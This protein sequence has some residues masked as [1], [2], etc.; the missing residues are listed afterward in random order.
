M[1][2]IECKKGPPQNS[3]SIYRLGPIGVNT[4]YW[5]HYSCMN[6]EEQAKVDPTI[7]DITEILEEVNAGQ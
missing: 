1:K 5:K 7:L 3:K 4:G 2:C 6:E